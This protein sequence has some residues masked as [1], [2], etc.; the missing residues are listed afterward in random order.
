MVYLHSFKVNASLTNKE[1]EDDV[2]DYDI[3]GA[4]VDERGGR[5]AAVRLPVVIP[6]S[7]ERFPDLLQT[8]KHGH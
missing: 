5:V 7:A 3:E 8:N 1:I 2:G 6:L 4:E